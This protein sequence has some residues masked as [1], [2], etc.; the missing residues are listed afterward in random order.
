MNS[1]QRMNYLCKSKDTVL[2]FSRIQ[3]TFSTAFLYYIDLCGLQNRI[4]IFTANRLESATLLAQDFC[5]LPW[6]LS[7]LECWMSILKFQELNE[8][9]YFQF[10]SVDIYYLLP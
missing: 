9:K 6:P 5:L 10:H 4:Y 3:I 7:N 8:N 2:R 1:F